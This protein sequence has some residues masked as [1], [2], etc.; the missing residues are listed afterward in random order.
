MDKI[1]ESLAEKYNMADF[2]GFVS[3]HSELEYYLTFLVQ[4]DHIPNKIVEAQ[5]FGE[6]TEDYTEI[7]QARDFCRTKINELSGT[8]IA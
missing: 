7:L 4:T 1:P 6:E 2:D 3:S 5:Y 8:D